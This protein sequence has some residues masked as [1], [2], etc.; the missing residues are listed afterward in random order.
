MSVLLVGLPH[1]VTRAVVERLIAQDD[2][3]RTIE[4]DAEHAAELKALGAFIAGGDSGDPDLIERAAQNVRTIVAGEGVR[5]G[6]EAI[7]EGARLAKVERLVFVGDAPD[8][9]V[10][11]SWGSVD[12]KVLLWRGR[13]GR[14]RDSRVDAKRTAIAIDAADDLAGE[15]DLD[16][17][18]HEADSWRA[19]GLA[20]A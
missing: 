15:I 9:S 18:L 1:D 10:T 8:A 11:R 12:Q 13:R 14:L 3:V 2:E 17:D 5:E 6:L 7:A 16:L 4:N 20:D 19:L